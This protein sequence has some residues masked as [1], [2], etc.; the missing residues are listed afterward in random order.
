[1][2]MRL[3]VSNV[4]LQ[5]VAKRLRNLETQAAGG[6]KLMEDLLAGR[7]N[8]ETDN[9]ICSEVRERLIAAMTSVGVAPKW[10]HIPETKEPRFAPLY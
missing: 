10:E 2:A 1:M 4:E 5:E 9:R 8:F 6:A 3:V 7:T